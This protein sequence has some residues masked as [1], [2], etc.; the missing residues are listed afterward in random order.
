V[1]HPSPQRRS[2]LR[3]LAMAPLGGGLLGAGLGACVSVGSSEGAAPHLHLLL[4]DAA[5]TDV[6]PLP[7][8]LVHALL[9]QP[10]PGNALADTTSIAYARR[11][12]A[13]AFYQLASWTERP[14]RQVPRLLQQRLERRGLAGAVGLLGDP[15]QADW[16]L[17][18]AVDDV[19]HDVSRDPGVARMALTVDLFDRRSRT[20]VARHQFRAESTALRADSAAAAAAMSQCVATLFDA[21]LPWLEQALSAA[22]NKP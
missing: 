15:L 12:H 4:R 21:L 19:H 10:Q 2:L 20:R 11:A 17:T 3:A 13:Y 5:P 18:L 22:T 1:T 16:L 6:Q 8:P 14:V 9:I 7:S